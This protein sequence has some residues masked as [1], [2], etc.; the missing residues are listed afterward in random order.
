MAYRLILHDSN[1]MSQRVLLRCWGHSR[2]HGFSLRCCHHFFLEATLSVFALELAYPLMESPASRK[3]D[4][5][6]TVDP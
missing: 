2:E 3:G 6:Y 4:A 1:S 5:K